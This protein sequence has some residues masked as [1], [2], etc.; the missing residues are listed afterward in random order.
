[1]VTEKEPSI[2][3]ARVDVITGRFVPTRKGKLEHDKAARAAMWDVLSE[4]VESGV[5]SSRA[6]LHSRAVAA[7]ELAANEDAGE[8]GAPDGE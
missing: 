5:L 6:V 8:E 1:M 7:L 3:Y 4:I 2:D